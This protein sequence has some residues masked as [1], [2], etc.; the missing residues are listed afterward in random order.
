[1]M[2]YLFTLSC[3]DQPGIVA[4]VSTALHTTGA[5]ILTNHQ[6]TDPVSNIFVMRTRFELVNRSDAGAF[7]AIQGAL[8]NATAPFNAK[9][10]VR[11]ETEVQRMMIMVSKFDHCLVDLLYRWR[12]GELPVAIPL[13]VSN[14]PD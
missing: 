6:F 5:N 1:M 3:P 9:T 4:A 10:R 7:A 13:V 12:A 2:T 14:H 8:N 11:L